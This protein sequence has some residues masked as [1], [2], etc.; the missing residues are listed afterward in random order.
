MRLRDEHKIESIREKA[1][2]MIAKNGLESLSM[3]KL[4]KAANVSPATIYI[5]FENR[6]DM[7]LQL[8]R[9]VEQTFTEV[10]LSG[11][12]PEMPFREGLWLQWKNRFRFVQRYPHYQKFFEQFTI[13]PCGPDENSNMRDFKRSMGQFMKS[14]QKRGEIVEL[15]PELFWS[16]AYGPFYALL[17]FHNKEKVMMD[18]DFQLT[19]ATMRKV[20]E[21]VIA[22][23]EP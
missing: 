3:Q 23:L 2:E 4:A 14:A 16:I 17:R 5:Y 19:E 8:Y 15:K 21:R 18:K 12:D 1:I 22:A 7:L 10:M 20:F 13:S 9:E 11:F 6:E